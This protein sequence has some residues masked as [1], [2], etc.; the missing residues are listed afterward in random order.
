MALMLKEKNKL[1]NA[2]QAELERKKQELNEEKKGTKN[3]LD[4]LLEG[5][6]ELKAAIDRFDNREQELLARENEV[7]LQG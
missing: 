3:L 5:E 4:T 7:Q 2:V 1:F 6:T